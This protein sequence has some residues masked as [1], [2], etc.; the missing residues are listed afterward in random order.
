[1][2]MTTIDELFEHELKDIYGAEQ[3]LLEALDEM[4][5]ETTDPDARKAF[6]Q[7]RK[8]TQNQIKRL[9]RVFKSIDMKPEAQPC[10]GLEGLIKEKKA[11]AKEKPSEEILSFSNLHAAQKVE[12][13]EI[14]AY[15]GL[16]EAAEHL[17]LD[18]AAKLLSQNLEEE[19]AALNKLKALASEYDVEELRMSAGEDQEEEEEEEEMI[20]AG[21]R[22]RR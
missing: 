8:E 19:E 11:L 9:D 7:H 20:A 13:Y 21:P 1:M 10:P 2:A 6:Q 3:R 4:A 17:G 15:E 16:I 22:R 12:R 5:A 14:T 18:E